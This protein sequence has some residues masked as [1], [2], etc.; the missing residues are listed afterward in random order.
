[1]QI[2][3]EKGHVPILEMLLKNKARINSKDSLGRT[4]LHCAAKHGHLPA[5]RLLVENGARIDC[6]TAGDTALD[7]AV[8]RGHYK[9]VEY[10]L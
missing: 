8:E 10:L 1:L 6:A 4:A 2:A 7:V 5:V 3:A 9:T